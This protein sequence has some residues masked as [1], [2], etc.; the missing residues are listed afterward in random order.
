MNPQAERQVRQQALDDGRVQDAR[1][2]SPPRVQADQPE[3]AAVRGHRQPV[4]PDR[5]QAPPRNVRELRG[6]P[7]YTAT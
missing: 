5:R 1:D 7:T 6:P 2:Q 3:Q 4:D